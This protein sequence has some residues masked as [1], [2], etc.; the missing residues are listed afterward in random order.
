MPQLPAVVRNAL[1]AANAGDTD[2]FISLFVPV[3]GCVSDWGR[4]SRGAEA[5]RAWSDDEFIGKNVTLEVVTFYRTGTDDVV[6]IV[7]VGGDGYN[8]P[9]TLTFRPQGDLLADMRIFA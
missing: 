7:Q 4:E 2:A 1:E 8:G 3:T 9:C 6:V 5:I